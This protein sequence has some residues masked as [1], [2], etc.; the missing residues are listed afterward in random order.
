MLY[1]RSN[2]FVFAFL[3]LFISAVSVVSAQDAPI[4]WGEIPMA[5]LKMKSFPD[6]TNATAVILCDYGDEFVNDNIDLEFHRHIRVKILNSKGFDWGDFSV[7]IFP[8]DGKQRISEIEGATYNLDNNGEI[9]VSELDD[10]DIFEDEVDDS[11]T[12]Y[13]FTLPNLKPGCVIEVRYKIISENLF[14]VEDW[15]FQHNEPTLWSEYRLAFPP[16]IAYSVVYQG[17]EPWY[18]SSTETIKKYCSGWLSRVLNNNLPSFTMYHYIVKN[19]PALRNEPF[20]TTIDDYFNRVNVQLAG[21][22]FPSTG[23]KEFLRNWDETV[24]RL[25]ESDS[26]Y[27]KIDVSGDVEDL[28]EEI[29]K[30]LTTP[31]EKLK[32][33][34]SWVSKSIVWT[35]ERRMTADKDPDDVIESKKGS[36]SEMTF[37]LLSLL[38]SVGINGDPLILSTRDNGRIQQLYP[39]TIQF[40]YC[41]AR[42]KMGGVT[43][44]LDPTDPYR[45][46]D[47]LPLRILGVKSLVIKEGPIEWIDLDASK[48]SVNSVLEVIKIKED[49]SIE[50]NVE[51]KFGSYKSLAA[52]QV[53]GSNTDKDVAK[54]FLEMEP[55]AITIDS[56]KII[57]KDSLENSLRIKGWISSSSYA[58]KSGKMIYFNPL[59][60]H[61]IKENPLKAKERKF[62]VDF[63]YRTGTKIIQNIILPEGYEL[64]ESLKNKK[65]MVGN[66]VQFIRNLVAD[67]N[68]VQILTELDI[69]EA[70]I[71]SDDYNALKNFY[72]QIVSAE[73]E[74]LVIGPIEKSPVEDSPA[75]GKK[76]TSTGGINE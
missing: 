49:G 13:R 15:T 72:A 46:M 66:G 52:R 42:V 10:D 37:L 73:S 23:K 67:G 44:Y 29:T 48:P 38:K 1:Y 3:M 22:V 61:R 32:A 41:I 19:A 12:R 40:N 36:S 56:V 11:R 63:G 71:S 25:L 59:I 75:G 65:F 43:Y 9:K 33:I 76:D 17:Y 27:E 39:I 24:K 51:D 4:K 58:Q 16:N 2:L 21:Y 68:I 20:I 34:Y 60:T 47:V 64:K 57:G 7:T 31:E 70:R 6:D 5:D 69:K 54:L 55:E 30:G 26:F 62:P 35:G 53:L 50:G 18:Y 8:E 28:A 14:Y 74:Q 45:P